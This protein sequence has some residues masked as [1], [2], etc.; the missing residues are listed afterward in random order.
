MPVCA[1]FPERARLALAAATLLLWGCSRTD[2]ELRFELSRLD[3]SFSDGWVHVTGEQ[4]LSLSSE[5]RN[6]LVHGVPLTIELELKVREKLSRSRVGEARTRYEI[7]YLP[8]SDHYQLSIPGGSDVMTFPRLRHV[9]AELS[10][11]DIAVET[12]S[13]PSGSYELLARIRLDEQNLPPPMR[14]PV[15]LSPEWR[16]DSKWTSWP[17]EVEP[18]V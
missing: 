3:T 1:R 13:L 7:R 18:E 5:A 10:R 6:A 17:L 8:L 2:G 14:L 16:H 11:L 12:G 9:L 4:K 15:F